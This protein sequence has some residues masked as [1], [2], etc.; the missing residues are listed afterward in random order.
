MDGLTP[1]VRSRLNH[2]KILTMYEYILP[3]SNILPLRKRMEPII[4]LSY[5]NQILVFKLMH[6]GGKI[7]AFATL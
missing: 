3:H 5:E 4:N 2:N 1:S 7:K 6:C